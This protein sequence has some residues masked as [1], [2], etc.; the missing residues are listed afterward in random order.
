MQ[1]SAFHQPESVAEAA[2]L[3]AADPEARPLAGG[4]TLVAMMNAELV[5]PSALVSLRRIAGLVG[6]AGDDAGW[7]RVGAM[8]P[9][10]V[11]AAAAA[12]LAGG[13]RVLA[14]AAGQIANP[15]VRNMGTIGGS[16]SFA[17]PAADYPPTLLA[18]GA[19][20][21][22][23]GTEGSRRVAAAE[24]FLDYYTT[25]LEPG[26]LVTAVHLPPAPAGSVGHYV[27]LARVA[28]DFATASIAL[29]LAMEGEACRAVRIA[30]GG[31]NPVPLRLAEAEAMLQGGRLEAEAVRAAGEALA[32]ASDPV[33]D[34]RASADY[35]RRVIPRLLARAITEA[36]ALARAAE[37]RARPPGREGEGAGGTTLGPLRAAGE[38]ALVVNGRARTVADPGRTL[39]EVL[40][41]ELGLTG[42]KRGCNQG[43]CGACT[44]LV[45][46]RPMRSCLSLAANCAGREV[47]TVEGL[48]GPATERLR[49]AFAA[50]GAVQC[51]FCTPGMLAALQ[52]LLAA[53]G[54]PGPDDVR[55]AISGNLCR[56]SGYRKIVDA[57]LVATAAE[58]AA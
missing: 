58:Q 43:V 39:L 49:E 25:V 5:R 20:I 18:A 19:E 10:Q 4:A 7:V 31:C 44:V 15:V 36:L 30:V 51:G 26:E 48:G 12:D 2:A 56:C 17:D 29:V 34:G 24:F 38:G 27:K 46:G 6:I 33:D 11:S 23:A 52:P 32:A 35:R 41:D 3:L 1:A 45:D 9:H 14:S 57:V 40:R 47:V 16:I 53:G 8:T 55:A 54:R 22:I 28:G 50:V 42:A 21:E 37:R 13:Q